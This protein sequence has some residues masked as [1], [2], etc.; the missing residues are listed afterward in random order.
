VHG[1]EARV[2]RQSLDVLDDFFTGVVQQSSV[3]QFS[4]HGKRECRP[5]NR[6]G[7]PKQSWCGSHLIEY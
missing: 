5:E 7:K 3:I 1:L 6:T 4:T 2:L